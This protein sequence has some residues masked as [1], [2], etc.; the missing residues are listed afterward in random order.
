MA[1]VEPT[2]KGGPYSKK[3]REDRRMQVY[4]LHFEE[5]LSAVKIAEM[6]DV[7][8]NTVNDDITF[9]YSQL[10]NALKSQ[11]VGA[12]IAKQIQRTDLQRERLLE[13][14]EEAK[15]I[16]EKI[17]IEKIISDIDSRMMQCFSKIILKGKSVLNRTVETE[18]EESEIR[19]FVRDLIL[20]DED[21]ESDDLYSEDDLEFEFVS[22]TKCDVSY[23]ESVIARMRDY[24]LGLC[25]QRNST[26]FSHSTEYD[27][28][29]FA[30]LRG[31][32]TKN[33]V[34]SVLK[35]RL[36]AEEEAD[37]RKRLREDKFIQKYGK[38]ESK[39]PEDIQEMFY[40]TDEMPE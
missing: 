5:N 13:L 30:D 2:K 10:S 26:I 7:N 32:V 33:E 15:T 27:L 37:K 19:E 6:L 18:I 31:Y 9:W 24:G 35:K 3:E 17:R 40:E 21:P 12:N 20:H 14:L 22:R 16:D 29:K 36:R 39:W 1:L 8:R 34:D 23:A 25:E 11:D 4:H 28:G 38:D